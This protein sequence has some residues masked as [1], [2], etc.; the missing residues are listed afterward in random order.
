MGE[1]LLTSR[2][3]IETRLRASVDAVIG[4]RLSPK[5]TPVCAAL[6]PGLRDALGWLRQLADLAKHHRPVAVEQYPMLN[7]SSYSPGQHLRFN[8]TSHAHQVAR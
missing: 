7:V 1:L 4:Q 2:D 6:H 3:A 5:S 8:I